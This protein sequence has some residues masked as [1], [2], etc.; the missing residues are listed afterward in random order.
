MQPQ[1]AIIVTHGSPY[2]C[3]AEEFVA[4]HLAHIGGVVLEPFEVQFT[5]ALDGM[6]LI[7]D[8]F[9]QVDAEVGMVPVRVVAHMHFAITA[10]GA[11]A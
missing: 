1:A 7:I 8:I 10:L 5:H 4:E 11:A 3:T 6:G 2:A 9:T